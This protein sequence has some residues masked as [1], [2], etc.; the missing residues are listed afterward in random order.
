LDRDLRKLGS[1]RLGRGRLPPLGRDEDNEVDTG[2]EERDSREED[3]REVERKDMLRLSSVFSFSSSQ[4][5]SEPIAEG[6]RGSDDAESFTDEEDADAG[7]LL[8]TTLGLAGMTLRTTFG[9]GW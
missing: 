5:L 9:W 8:M 3:G 1:S 6:G 2:R 4:S 7:E